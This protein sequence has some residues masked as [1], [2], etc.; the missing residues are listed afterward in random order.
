[1]Q[2]NWL[3]LGPVGIISA[4]NFPV[5]VWAWNAALALVCGDTCVW[6]PS[7]KT[8]LTA[9]ACQALFEQAV[10]RSGGAPDGLAAVVI[11]A[12]EVGEQLNTDGCKDFYPDTG[13]SQLSKQLN[14]NSRRLHH[15]NTSLN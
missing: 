14:T 12:K 2:E 13:L 7:E 10:M 1:M 5:A 11:G 8:P 9:L 15:P 3:P 4:F 6:K